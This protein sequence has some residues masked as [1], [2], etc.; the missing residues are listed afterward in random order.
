MLVESDS[1]LVYACDASS[2]WVTL[3]SVTIH[4]AKSVANC[5]DWSGDVYT[6]LVPGPDGKFV[7]NGGNAG[8]ASSECARKSPTDNAR[9][10]LIVVVVFKLSFFLA[11]IFNGNGVLEIRGANLTHPDQRH[12]EAPS[13]KVRQAAPDGRVLGRFVGGWEISRFSGQPVAKATQKIVRFVYMVHLRRSFTAEQRMFT[14]VNT[15]VE[16]EFFQQIQMIP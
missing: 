6:E 7:G 12:R 3:K 5:A 13:N 14:P 11:Q 16:S 9:S 8:W 1:R 2:A 15:K 10:F 4:G